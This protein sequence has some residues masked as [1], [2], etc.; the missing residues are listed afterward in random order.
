[1][2]ALVFKAIGDIELQDVADP[3]IQDAQDVIV[4][5]TRS[6]IC[7]T[8][9][10]FIRGTVPGVA[11]NTILGHE[12][13]GIV[14][15]IG[16]EVKTV[17]PGDRV[18]IPSTIGCGHCSYCKQEIYA[19]CDNA[20]PHGPQAGT[21]FFGGPQ[22]TGPF[23]GMQAEKV[24]V[25]YADAMLL[26]IPKNVTDDQAILLSDILPT[27]YMAVEM[28][29]IHTND[30]I[31]VFGC[32]PVGQL[33]IACLKKIGIKKIFAVD[34]IPSRLQMARDQGSYVI[35]FDEVDPVKKLQELTNGQG[36]DRIIDAVGIDAQKSNRL[37][38]IF[39]TKE[40][41][42]ELDKIV[43]HPQPDN[44]NWVPG[45]GPS[46]A[47]QWAVKA[48]AKAGTISIIGVYPQELTSFAIGAAMNKNVTIRMGNCN[49][50]KYLPMLLE[51]IEKGE[52]N[53]EHF[54][55]QKVPFKEI[56]AAYKHFDA[57]EDNWIK[58]VLLM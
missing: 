8:D 43:P 13:V 32:G 1:M 46:Q 42:E 57:R 23:N 20:N 6:A 54:I 36:P 7:G 52:F 24:R 16:K 55:T 56:I 22:S 44:G 27:A 26:K 39:N 34:H 12:G 40:F 41:K 25:P 3:A 51:W 19:Q 31:A 49:H 50:R 35:N 11:K 2:K 53:I 17:K 28:V 14:E 10:H 5:L 37:A 18:I 15:E 21:A 45:N 9:L 30:T 29:N 48:I 33:V 4:R 58:V 47:L 38:D